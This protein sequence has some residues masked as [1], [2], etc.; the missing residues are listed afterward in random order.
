MIYCT[1]FCIKLQI[2]TSYAMIHPTQIYCNPLK[3]SQLPSIIHSVSTYTSI[4]DQC[5]K[6]LSRKIKISYWWISS[7]F[8]KVPI[9]MLWCKCS[10][11]LYQPR[12]WSW[13]SFIFTLHKQFIHSRSKLELWV[14]SLNDTPSHTSNYLPWLMISLEI[15]QT[16]I[17]LFYAHPE[18]R[19]WNC[20]KFHQ[21][22]LI[23]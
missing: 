16:K 3:T 13:S 15:V 22:P 9:W 8:M 10:C 17:M 23:Q 7:K 6:L 20:V 5:S 12:L 4:S 14:K 11:L 19:Y 1:T 21:C 2:I 18:V